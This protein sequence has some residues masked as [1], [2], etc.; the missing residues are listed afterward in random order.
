M[1]ALRRGV[2]DSGLF[3]TRIYRAFGLGV[4]SDAA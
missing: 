4:E 2:G 1:V 3:R